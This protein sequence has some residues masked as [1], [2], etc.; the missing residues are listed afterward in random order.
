[1]SARVVSGDDIHD[2]TEAVEDLVRLASLAL[3]NDPD[4]SRDLVV[5]T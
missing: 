4:L 3:E 5:L 1:V 2:L